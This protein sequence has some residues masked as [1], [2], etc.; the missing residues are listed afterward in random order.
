VRADVLLSP[1]VI[2]VGVQEVEEG[3]VG[4]STEPV[5]KDIRIKPNGEIIK[6]GLKK[7]TLTVSPMEPRMLKENI[8]QAYK[9]LHLDSLKRR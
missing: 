7:D 2:V 5:Q 8:V 1:T 3:L 6:W 4:T 9:A